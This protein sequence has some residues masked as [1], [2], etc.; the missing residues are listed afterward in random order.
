MVWSLPQ[1]TGIIEVFPFMVTHVGLSLATPTQRELG[2][3][4]GKFEK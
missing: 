1:Y 4:S 2:L 3:A